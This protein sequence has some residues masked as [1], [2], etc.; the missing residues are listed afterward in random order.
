MLTIIAMTA[1]AC[2]LSSGSVT[3]RIDPTQSVVS[4]KVP[5]FGIGSKSATFPNMEGSITIDPAN[6]GTINLRV[7]LDGRALEASDGLTQRRLKGEKFF[8]VDR[9]PEITFTGAA[10]TMRNDTAGVVDGS[11]SAR[12]KRVGAT[13]DVTFDRP[14][15]EICG[16]RPVSFTARTTIDRR[17]YG[18]T[19]Y[20]LIVGNKVSINIEARMV[21]DR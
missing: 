20:G 13:L 2:S 19:S 14:T 21:P 9:Y 7:Q 4:A 5:F 17:H 18:M 11:I 6:A 16:N 3:Y 12:G 10:L 1:A 8:W 15:K